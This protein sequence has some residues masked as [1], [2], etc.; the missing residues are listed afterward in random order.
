MMNNLGDGNKRRLNCCDALDCIPDVLFSFSKF[1]IGQKVILKEL[2]NIGKESGWYSSKHFLVPGNPAIIRDIKLIVDSNKD[3]TIR[4]SF[5][6]YLEYEN[7]TWISSDELNKGNFDNCI[8]DVKKDRHNLFRFDEKLICEYETG[9]EYYCI[10]DYEKNCNSYKIVV[11]AKN[12]K[13][14]TTI[15]K[16]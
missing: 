10:I 2:P 1:N 13:L 14:E 15:T 9:K 3:G 5:D 4:S 8:N 7:E 6:C 12:G 16:E 11:F